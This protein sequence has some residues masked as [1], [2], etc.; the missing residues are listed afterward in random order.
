MSQ[1]ILSP[2]LLTVFEVLG[3]V[4]VDSY[5][6]GCKSCFAN[7]CLADLLEG[8]GSAR[9]VVLG[10]RLRLVVPLDVVAL[11]ATVRK[12]VLPQVCVG[13]PE[14][15]CGDWRRHFHRLAWS[16]R[17]FLEPYFWGC[18]LPL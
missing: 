1:E 16:L 8:P 18:S 12:A 2:T 4:P 11:W 5:F 14:A 13:D 15:S 17:W 9:L 6:V 7:V 3:H 10:S